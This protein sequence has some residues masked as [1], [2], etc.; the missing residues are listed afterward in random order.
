MSLECWILGNESVFTGK[1]VS[2]GA[3]L[4]IDC[5]VIPGDVDYDSAPEAVICLSG[6]SDTAAMLEDYGSTVYNRSS[7]V[8]I[9][10]DPNYTRAFIRGLGAPFSEDD[11]DTR[12]LII[13]GRPV[14][15][16][17]LDGS[18]PAEITDSMKG[19]I[20]R[21]VP[22]LMSDFLVADF[23]ADSLKWISDRADQMPAEGADADPAKMI[24]EYVAHSKISL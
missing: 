17:R 20:R 9:C 23:A 2:E 8:R 14:S 24:M 1:L 22:E 7:V 12:V 10:N 4:G 3:R 13:G 5:S 21:M 6:D 16:V 15:A 11:A 18:G 19:I